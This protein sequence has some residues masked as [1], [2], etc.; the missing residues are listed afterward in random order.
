ML[1]PAGFNWHRNLGTSCCGGKQVCAE[2]IECLRY[3]QR[4]S[5]HR[6]SC[7]DEDCASSFRDEN[8]PCKTN[9]RVKRVVWQD[10]LWGAQ[11]C[12]LTA[13]GLC[14]QPLLL[15]IKTSKERNHNTGALNMSAAMFLLGSNSFQRNDTG[16]NVLFS[17]LTSKSLLL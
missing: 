5:E 12:I 3:P 17:V 16:T 8:M 13:S 6:Y 7:I 11:S 2:A 14:F 9:W 15:C 10:S 4:V 1:T